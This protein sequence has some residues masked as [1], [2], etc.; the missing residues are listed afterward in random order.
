MYYQ[1]TK[2]HVLLAFGFF[3]DVVYWFM[4][5][6]FIAVKLNNSLSSENMIPPDLQVLKLRRN[7]L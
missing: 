1:L 6:I 5:S 4:L 2:D 7:Y 3:A